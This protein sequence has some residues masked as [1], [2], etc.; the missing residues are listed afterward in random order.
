MTD[1]L[2]YQH[3]LDHADA[4]GRD[5]MKQ[6]G[7]TERLF[8]VGS[9]NHMHLMIAVPAELPFA[10]WLLEN[11]AN[12]EIAASRQGELVLI[13]TPVETFKSRL[14]YIS[15]FTDVLLENRIVCQ[16]LIPEH[17]PA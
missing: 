14:R 2:S 8:D 17:E 7:L 1:V 4:A 3:I 12:T 10:Q 9:A 11:L 13:S 16:T 6:V 15:A 5:A